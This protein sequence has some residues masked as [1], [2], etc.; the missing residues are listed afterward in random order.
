MHDRINA[1]LTVA[2]DLLLL[3]LVDSELHG[4]AQALSLLNHGDRIGVDARVD[5]RIG[6]L[7]RCCAHTRAGSSWPCLYTARPS[8]LGECTGAT[9]ANFGE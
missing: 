9:S 1:Q 4:A 2:R 7:M 5:G 6:G 3:V 8:R